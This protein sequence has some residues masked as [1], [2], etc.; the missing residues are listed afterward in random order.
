MGRPT[1]E[2]WGTVMSPMRKPARAHDLALHRLKTQRV[3]AEGLLQRRVDPDQLVQRGLG[4]LAV[5]LGVDALDL[6]RQGGE[7]AAPWVQAE[8]VDEEFGQSQ[9]AGVAGEEVHDV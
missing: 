5:A 2:P 6:F 8:E 4:P 1:T 3:Q 9:G 7:M